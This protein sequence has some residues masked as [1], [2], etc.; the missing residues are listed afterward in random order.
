M[1]G[2][3]R[4]R[5]VPAGGIDAVRGVPRGHVQRRRRPPRRELVRVAQRLGHQTLL[6]L[7]LYLSSL[8]CLRSF[9]SVVPLQLQLEADRQLHIMVL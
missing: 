1:R 5:I 9:L 2:T 3:V 7:R 6:H 4:R 8:S